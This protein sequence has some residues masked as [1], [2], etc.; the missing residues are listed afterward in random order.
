ML[1]STISSRK[2]PRKVFQIDIWQL[3]TAPKSLDRGCRIKFLPSVLVRR[4]S[5][6]TGKNNAPGL[7]PVLDSTHCSDMG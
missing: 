7:N 2:R 3:V 4:A 1:S 5:V 6:I